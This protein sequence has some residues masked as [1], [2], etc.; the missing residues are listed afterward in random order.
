MKILDKWGYIIR[1]LKR[2]T[3]NI[4]IGLSGGLDTCTILS[5]LL[6]SNINLTEVLINSNKDNISLHEQDFI[7]ANKTASKFGLKLPL[8]LYLNLI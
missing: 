1:S 5:I 4:S 2:K 6:I 3:N 7:I 8:I